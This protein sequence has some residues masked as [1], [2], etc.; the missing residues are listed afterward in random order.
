MT[1]SLRHGRV[2]LALHE[3][4]TQRSDPKQP[5]LLALHPLGSA[6]RA[7]AER[8]RTWPSAA[9]GLDFSGHGE[10]DRISGGGYHPELFLAEA[11]IALRYLDEPVLVV[12]A[13]VGAYVAL[14]LAGSRPDA[15]QAALLLDGRGLA[16]GGSTPEFDRWPESADDF[17]SK[18]D[19]AHAEF[20]AP[21]DPYV[22]MCEIDLRPLDYVESFARAANALH[23]ARL[24]SEAPEWWQCAQSV[25]KPPLSPDPYASLRDSKLDGFAG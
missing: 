16:A 10:S 22:F 9:F 17:T 24:A 25:A 18:L 23:F 11:D 4:D 19:R 15:V 6:T 13:G 2:K 1:I 20:D 14:L 5:S 21:T 3:L 8:L 12:G 7:W